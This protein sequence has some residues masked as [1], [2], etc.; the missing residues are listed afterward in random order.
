M[1]DAI[2]RFRFRLFESKTC[3]L[4]EGILPITSESNIF[5][6]LKLETTSDVQ[7]TRQTAVF[8]RLDGHCMILLYWHLKFVNLMNILNSINLVIS[9]F[10]TWESRSNS[11]NSLVHHTKLSEI[12]LQFF[13]LPSD[14]EIGDTIFRKFIPDYLAKDHVK[15]WLLPLKLKSY[16]GVPFAYLHLIRND[17]KRQ[18]HVMHVST[19]TKHYASYFLKKIIKL[20]K[21]SLQFT[22]QLY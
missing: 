19:E 9:K 15:M 16:E 13:Y 18:V 8:F 2:Y 17:S 1:H 5:F 11:H 4:E 7:L 6:L 20:Q 12:D 21:A 10:F 22:F 3:L 14:D